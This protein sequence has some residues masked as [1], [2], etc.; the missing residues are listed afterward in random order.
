[1]A[2]WASV[3]LPSTN[4]DNQGSAMREAPAEPEATLVPQANEAQPAALEEATAVEARTNLVAPQ[5][6]VAAPVAILVA[7]GPAAPDIESLPVGGCLSIFHSNW[8]FSSWAHS[9][10]HQGVGWK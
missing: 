8:T 4:L 2:L 6:V 5:L 9:L 7:P 1:M 10:V 3:V